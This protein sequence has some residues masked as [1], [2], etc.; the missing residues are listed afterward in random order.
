MNPTAGV[1][2]LDLSKVRKAGYEDDQI[3]AYVQ[4]NP[5]IEIYDS[6][7]PQQDEVP[8]STQESPQKTT[9]QKAADW[10]PV[11]GAIGGSFIPGVG[12]IAG[13]AVGAGLGT[14]AKQFLDDKEGF[15]GGE[16]VKETALGAVGGVAGKVVGKGLSIGGKLLSK[17][18]GKAVGNLSDEAAQSISKA[19][20]T[21][22]RK[23][24]EQH[25]VDLNNLIK[26]HVSSG[27]G[28]DDLI[29]E[30]AKRSNGGTIGKS[31]EV[32]EK[33]IQS[34][35]TGAGRNIRIPA[36]V[37]MQDLKAEAKVLAMIPGNE[38]KIQAIN[39]IVTSFAK[40]YKNGVSV[41]RALDL[42][43]VADSKFGQAVVNDEVGSTAT[44]AQ[45]MIANA[46]RSSIKKMFPEIADALDVQSELLTL[47]PIFSHARA[48]TKTGGSSIRLG[49]IG[50][51][52]ATWFEAYLDSPERASKL[53]NMPSMSGGLGASP[54][55]ATLA[56]RSAAQ[57]A[58]RAFGGIGYPEGEL[59][60][61]NQDLNNDIS[62]NNSP[63]TDSI[64][65]L[66]A[67]PQDVSLTDGAAMETPTLTGYTPEKIYKAYST[68][69]AQGDKTSAAYFR[70][71][72]EDE[73][74]YQ[75]DQAKSDKP[76]K[77]SADQQKFANAALA[78]QQ[79]LALLESG[80]VSS[81]IGQKFIGSIGEKLGTNSQTQQ[82]YRSSIAVA[83]TA[84]RNAMLG[85]NMTDKE[86]ESLGAFIPEYDDA[87]EVAKTKLRT[88]VSIME[89]FG[90][91]F[92]GTAPDYSGL[93]AMPPTL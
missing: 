6:S 52:P 11:A 44:M 86:L 20:P 89:S 22:W 66:G 79:A 84:A 53:L 9:L 64:A 49:R 65:G 81:G 43:R 14:V 72:W 8:Q 63:H 46:S 59:N 24:A 5:N 74:K 73:S 10:L 38:N 51:N 54:Q 48:I 57:G 92:E 30:V 29:G 77:K 3:I 18:A 76:A 36:D 80:D 58:V 15:D 56:G 60:G 32:A 40:Q 19:S 12:T 2:R 7:A 70:Q 33:Q 69:M 85:A 21:A 88:F 1:R 83:R 37:F 26:K 67:T 47:K 4:K 39:R 45:K 23:A 91:N 34:T 16:V 71:M 13:G 27:S 25:G 87:P 78:G 41:K 28:Y 31:L 61:S 68:A 42:K 75:A 93:G 82:E 50:L 62:S 90:Q 17:G 55:I 35:V